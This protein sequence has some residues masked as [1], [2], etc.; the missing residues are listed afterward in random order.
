MTQ[1]A[2]LQARLQNGD[3]YT[4]DLKRSLAESGKSFQVSWCAQHSSGAGPHV[5]Q[6]AHTM[7]VTPALLYTTPVVVVAK[8]TCANQNCKLLMLVLALVPGIVC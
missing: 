2:S 7:H 6:S 5:H 4:A 8:M 3:I 1:V